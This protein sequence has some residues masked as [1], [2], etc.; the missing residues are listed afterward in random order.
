VSWVSLGRALTNR[1]RPTRG[2]F[3]ALRGKV[4]GR[5]ARLNR[6]AIKQDWR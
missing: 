4:S 2:S 6:Y 3:V 5:A 1:P